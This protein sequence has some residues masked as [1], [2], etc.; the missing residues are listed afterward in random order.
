M[1]FS[2]IYSLQPP[3]CKASLYLSSSSADCKIEREIL[4][5]YILPRLREEH[6]DDNIAISI[7]DMR[8]FLFH[9]HGV[10]CC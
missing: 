6:R 2:C 10:M 4:F 9:I 8:Y 5:S 3:R 1:S 7:S